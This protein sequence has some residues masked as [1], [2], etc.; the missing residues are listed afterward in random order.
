VTNLP[1][2]LTSPFKAMQ[3]INGIKIDLELNKCTLRHKINK[4]ILFIIVSREVPTQLAIWEDIQ[5]TGRSSYIR[6]FLVEI[7]TDSQTISSEN[8]VTM[9]YAIM[10]IGLSRKI[11][12]KQIEDLEQRVDNYVSTDQPYKSTDTDTKPPADDVEESEIDDD[13]KESS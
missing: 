4:L 5:I 2:N 6:D 9:A 13:A 10:D 1:I 8:S 12:S 11:H 3:D 7:F